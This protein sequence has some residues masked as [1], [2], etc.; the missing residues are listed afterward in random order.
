MSEGRAEEA[1]EAAKKAVRLAPREF[2]RLNTLGD[3][4]VYARRYEDAIP[5]FKQV[6]VYS[7]S[8]LTAHWGL[9]V[10]YSELGREEEAR[11]AGAEMLRITPQ[12]TVERW[13][14]MVPQRDSAVIERWAA[15]LRKAG[16]K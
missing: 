14:R 12:F 8:L 6:L 2:L 4:Y 7:P 11:A 3:A 9:A 10:S 16:L 13:K 15:A 5:V 1:I